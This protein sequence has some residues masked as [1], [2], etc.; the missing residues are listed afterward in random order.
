MGICREFGCEPGQVEVSRFPDGEIHVQSHEDLRGKD[1][2][3]IQ[4]T[5]PPVNENLME[6]LIL[7]DCVK[8]SSAD[9]ITAVIPYF[10]YARQDRR[11]RGAH[12]P[13]SAK[14]IAN[15]IAAAGADRVLTMD[16]HAEQIQGFFDIPVDHLY[17]G[18]VFIDHFRKL[19][20]PDLVVVSPD[21]GSIK[22]ARAYSKALGARLATVDK[23]RISAEE[24]EVGFVIGE[25]EGRNALIS[26]DIIATGGSIAQAS[27]ILK[28]NGVKDIYIAATHPV[29]VG[30]AVE[31]LEASPIKG[32]FV[33]DTIPIAGKYLQN[34]VKVLSSAGLFADA[35]EQIH[36]SST[37]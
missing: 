11:E 20:I 12:V 16:L 1:V 9:R 27:R 35:I 13:I 37:I 22:M 10:G 3:I 21:V 15:L 30:P 7:T 36:R 25:V 33:T 28:D 34:R 32:V 2:F 6:L 29:L 19:E 23:R 8:R 17:G 14:L 18:P 26:D 31:K 5:C 4:S 24:T